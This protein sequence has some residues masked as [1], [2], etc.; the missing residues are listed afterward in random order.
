MR[1]PETAGP[2]FTGMASMPSLNTFGLQVHKEADRSSHT[3]K[4]VS[5]MFHIY[6]SLSF[7]QLK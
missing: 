3:K 2:S 7:A 1:M 6:I 4:A 5:E